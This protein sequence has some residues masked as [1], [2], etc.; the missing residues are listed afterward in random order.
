MVTQVYG[1]ANNFNIV[2]NQVVG[3]RWEA[4]LPDVADG[5]YVVEMFAEDDA[6][7]VA[8]FC[9]MLFIISG[10]KV[11]GYIVPAGFEGEVRDRNYEGLLDIKDMLATLNKKKYSVNILE[12]GYV[13][14]ATKC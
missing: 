12:R 1:K 7:N 3:N 13:L 11:M 10:H 6:G 8:Y 14:N 2:F 4:G 5:E 9:T